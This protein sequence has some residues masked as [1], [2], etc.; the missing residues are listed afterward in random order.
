MFAVIGR[1]RLDPEHAEEQR[2]ALT[3][4]IVPGVAQA[5]G[6]VAGHWSEPATTGEAHSFI[7]FEERDAAEAFA[8][9]VRRNRPNPEDRGVRDDDLVVVELMAHA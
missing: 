5:K 6:F 1:W 2:E 3:Q 8:E 9:R 7:V 4:R